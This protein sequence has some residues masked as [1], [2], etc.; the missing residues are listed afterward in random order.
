MMLLKV[1]IEHRVV[2]GEVGDGRFSV[3]FRF[4]CYPILHRSYFHFWFNSMHIKLHYPLPN[5]YQSRVAH[6]Y[7]SSNHNSANNNYSLC[8]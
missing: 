4:S 7:S 1:A 5:P 6:T 8:A 2:N 3:I